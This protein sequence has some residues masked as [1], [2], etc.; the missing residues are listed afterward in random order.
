MQRNP[1]KTTNYREK[2]SGRQALNDYN[3]Y[4]HILYHKKNVPS[5][6][7]LFHQVRGKYGY[8]DPEGILREASYG[9]T[10]VM[11]MMM[12][13]FLRRVMM[14]ILRRVTDDNDSRDGS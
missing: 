5:K 1:G 6:N 10:K 4:S 8:Y 3:Q 7:I 9:A 2:Y 11:M 13:I 12:M 14:M